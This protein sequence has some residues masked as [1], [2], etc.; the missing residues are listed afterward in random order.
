MRWSLRLSLLAALAA[1][2]GCT[3]PCSSSNC[4]G[5]CSADNECITATS[6]ASCGANGQAC[7]ACLST[8]T[9][10]PTQCIAATE[11]DAGTV[12]SG[13]TLD[14]GV[15][16]CEATPVTCRDQS[17][18]QLSLKTVVSDGGVTEEGATPGATTYI[19]ARGGGLMVNQSFTY[20][21][22]TRGG[23]VKVELT[24]EE[25][26]ES[27]EWDIA[28]PRYLIRLNSGVSG[29]SCVQG[30]RTVA[31]TT[32]ES[33]TS[34]PE[35]LNWRSEDYFTSSCD[36]IPDGSGLTSAASVLAS[37]WSYRSCLQMTDNVYV[38]H[39]RDG[40]HVKVQV[41]G[42]YDPAP[43]QVCNMTGSVPNPSGS[44]NMRIRWAYL[45]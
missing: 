21:K 40:H 37:F 3:T 19:D 31:N 28:L 17:T 36:L 27:M 41:L 32:F 6:V 42:Y 20:A 34:V 45:D 2:A 38:V 4:A 33:V 30:A 24:D 5:C 13:V 15:V 16:R 43:Q 14:A 9:C 35:N 1:L 23:L 10:G 22:F 7:V 18:M 12:D 26:F 44:G 29:P 25:A 39:L 11:V 8:E